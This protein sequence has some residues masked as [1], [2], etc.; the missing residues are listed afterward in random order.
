MQDF[1]MTLRASVSSADAHLLLQ[2]LIFDLRTVAP[3]ARFIYRVVR[4]WRFFGRRL[5]TMVSELAPD[6]DDDVEFWDFE[7]ATEDGS[8]LELGEMDMEIDI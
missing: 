2:E 6:T 4:A 3:V 7:T 1:G 5:P 8:D